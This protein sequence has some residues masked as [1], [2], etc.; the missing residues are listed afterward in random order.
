MK[1]IRLSSSLSVMSDQI[2]Q[3]E[4]RRSSDLLLVSVKSGKTFGIKPEYKESVSALHDRFV[5]EINESL[6]E[7]EQ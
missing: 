3:V 5:S 2:T 1:L 7:K 6:K 4:M